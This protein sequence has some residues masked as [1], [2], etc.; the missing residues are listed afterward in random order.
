MLKSMSQEDYGDQ[1]GTVETYDDE[2]IA[3]FL[4][5]AQS[6]RMKEMKKKH[7]LIRTT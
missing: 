3:R 1:I 5:I 4:R 7:T 6:Y 2:K